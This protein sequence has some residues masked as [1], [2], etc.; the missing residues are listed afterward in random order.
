M[1]AKLRLTVW[2]A[3][4]MLILCAIMLFFIIWVDRTGLVNDSPERLVETV[5]HNEEKFEAE[6]SEIAWDDVDFYIRGV[7][8]AFYDETGKLLRGVTVDG[9]NPSDIP[10]DEYVVQ[11]IPLDGDEFFVYDAQLVTR[12]G[13]PIWIRGIAPGTDDYGAAHLKAGLCT[14]RKN[15]SDGKLDKRRQRPHRAH[16]AAQ[17]PIGAYRAFKHL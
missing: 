10:F 4:M 9:L 3:A 14:G 13:Q 2:I 7:Y 17:R 12:D 16:S 8:C 5:S 1:S 6:H 11:S 15:N